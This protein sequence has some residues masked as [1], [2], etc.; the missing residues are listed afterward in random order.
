MKYVR[1]IIDNTSNHTDNFYTYAC[2]EDGIQPG[3]KVRVPFGRGNRLKDAY[4]FSIQPSPDPAENLDP[5]RIKKVVQI[6]ENLSLTE[7]LLRL[8]VWMRRTYLCRYIDAIR[9]MIPPGGAA[10]R[11][12]RRDPREEFSCDPDT[13][14]GLTVQQREAMAR[15]LPCIEGEY[16]STF[17][18]NGV[19]SSGKTEIYLRTAEEVLSRGKQVIVLVPEISLAPQTIGRFIGR[20]GAERVAVLHSRLTK[21]Q[22][23]DQ[24]MQVRNGK[25]DILI[26]ARL[27]VFAPFERLG[28]LIVDEEHESSYKSDMTP[29]Y[30]AVDAA[31]ERGKIDGAVVILGTATPSVVS[32]YRAFCGEYSEILLTERY[33]K[34][35][36]PNIS[37]ADM[38]K[39][40]RSGNRSIFSRNLY[41]KS[42][43]ALEAGKQVIFF[44]NRRGYASFISCRSCGFVLKCEVCGISMTYHQTSGMAECHYCGRRTA[45]P[46]ICP[47]CGSRYIRQFGIGTEKV[48]EMA[49]IA[50]PDRTVGR[51]DLD[52]ARRKGESEKILSAFR[53]GKTDILV[54]TQLV[55]KGL[56]FQNVG[57]VGII[58]ADV[59][60]NIPDY[61]SSERTFQL[62]TQAAGRAGRGTETG[63][64]VIQ[65]YSPDEAAI[66]C[67]AAG[68][69]E[70][71]YRRE[72]RLRSLGGYPPFTNIIRLVFY[73]S[74]ESCA[75]REAQ[76]A[77]LELKESGIAGRGE[78]FSPQPAYLNRMNEN[79][80]YHFIIKC[81]LEKKEKYLKIIF[82]IRKRRI[83]DTSV[84]SV[85]LIEIDPY[86]MT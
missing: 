49:K 15:I 29:K 18:L 74:D 52:T 44:L 41:R 65:T 28:A 10:K 24:W 84:K 36:L 46:H 64:V 51:L 58:S 16:H 33:N 20:F 47:S 17:L 66:R 9:C 12:K 50:F 75:R 72:L 55:A 19:T 60:M 71:F 27:G 14:P 35:P 11:G 7:D 5:S 30:D 70:G 42:L 13:A 25:A 21:G 62:I 1:V 79:Y 57:V 48:E 73:H 83:G 86:S 4:V 81:P 80:R 63:E 6:D 32:K 26:G 82:D 68:D 38:R 61:R 22:R 43:R 23:Y 59:T 76:A 69:Y 31:V 40:L 34:T 56:D 54:G 2:E 53:R 77:Y 78:L 67:A 45:V 3:A 8:C 39:E 85:M 37:I